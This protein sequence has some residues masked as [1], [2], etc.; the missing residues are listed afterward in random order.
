ML[1][2]LLLF[3]FAIT[4]L[5]HGQQ[6]ADLAGDWSGA[7]IVNGQELGVQFVFGYDDGILDGTLDIPQQSA[8]NLPVEF[9]L[10]EGDSIVFQFETG[11]GSAAFLGI[12][13]ESRDEISG[14]F[15]QL[16]TRFPFS[17]LRDTVS[18]NSQTDTTGTNLIIPTRSG[19]SSGTL[20]EGNSQ[21]PLVILLTGSGSQDRDENVAGFRIFAEL[22]EALQDSGY[23]SFRYDDRGV[24]ESEGPEDATLQDLSDDLQDVVNY[25]NENHTDVFDGIV[26]LGHSQGGLVA[27]LSAV[28]IS[29]LRGII[30]MASPF[31]SGDEIINRQIQA[32]S[33]AQGVN[34]SIVDKNLEFQA[35]IYDVVRSGGEW[36]QIE[37]DLYERLEEQINTLPEQQRTALGNMDSFIRSQISRQLAAAKTEWF[38]SFIEIEPSELIGSLEIPMLAVFGEK[39]M[40]VLAGP[41]R[42]AAESLNQSENLSLEIVTIPA[43]NHL[44]QQ[45]STGMPGEYGMLEK[46]FADGFMEA[47]IEWLNNL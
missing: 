46:R 1:R 5:L 15:E 4:Q 7:I 3:S 29:E 24:G 26:L 47:I 9:I 32:I 20:V 43:A 25:L 22:A 21:K 35:R 34:D 44:F 33:T 8:Y 37:Q 18:A 16:G 10:A 38:R 40:Q 11:T 42:E 45:A 14:Q 17:I 23:S 6:T 2:Y 19:Q 31:L 39:D 30:F 13:N 36:D 28:E 41:N 12:I 27:T